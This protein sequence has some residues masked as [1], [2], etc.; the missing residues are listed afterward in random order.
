[1]DIVNILENGGIGV[2]P[3]DTIYG[4]VGSALNTQTVEKIY[5]LKKRS[6]NKPF[7]ILISSL[8]DLKKFDI[9]L[10]KKQ[11]VFLQKIWP[12]PVSVILHSLAFRM[13]KNKKLLDLLDKTGPL[14]APSANI[15]RQK[16][17]ATIDEAKKYFGGKVDFYLDKG[18]IKSQPSTLIELATDGSYH[19]LRQGAFQKL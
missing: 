10:T 16:P 7:I 13:P 15:A 5:Q 8:D 4:I 19:I 12:N 2:M 11:E 6:K 3:T 17:A 18:K 1:M 9:K 14:V